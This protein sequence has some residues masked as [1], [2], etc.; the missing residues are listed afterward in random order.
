M[1]GLYGTRAFSLTHALSLTRA[2]SLSLTSSLA[3]LYL[4][5]PMGITERKSCFIIIRAVSLDILRNMMQHQATPQ[6]V[7]RCWTGCSTDE[8]E[9][10]KST[11]KESSSH[12]VS[13]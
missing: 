3:L 6:L 8:E 5:S 7:L 10:T 4:K 11:T 13:V 12:S 9:R 2:L 1:G